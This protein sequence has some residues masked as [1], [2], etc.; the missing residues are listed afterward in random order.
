MMNIL[1]LL[2]SVQPYLSTT[3]L[4][5][6]SRIVQA[7]LSMTGRVT[8]LGI[9]R[10]AG[11]GGSYR[12]VQWFFNTLITWTEMFGE[13]FEQQL[14]Q[15][16]VEYFL[17]G[18]ES[19]VTKS[20]KKTHGL[21]HFFSGLLSKTVKGIAIFALSLVSVEERRSYP[22]QVEQIVRSEAEK[23]AAKARQKKKP[24]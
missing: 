7:L 17:V 12:S 11:K 18:D 8:M 3:D 10:W 4:R 19:V 9:S 6:L 14:H 22:L 21:D 16:A 20:G 24:V 5:R 13:F 1:V 23:V 2:Q 15:P